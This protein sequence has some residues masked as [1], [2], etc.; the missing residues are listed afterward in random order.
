M[1]DDQDNGKSWWAAFDKA[2]LALC[3]VVALLFA[4][5]FGEDLYRGAP[6]TLRHQIYL[7]I[8]LM[9]AVT[10]PFVSRI[11][12]TMS[13]QLQQVARNLY[14][15]LAIIL[16]IFVYGAYRDIWEPGIVASLESQNSALIAWLEAAETEKATLNEWLQQAQRER[17]D[18]RK[19]L[20]QP[21]PLQ[22]SPMMSFPLPAPPSAAQECVTLA[23]RLADLDPAWASEKAQIE[24]IRSTMTAL[25]CGCDAVKK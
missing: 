9:F 13:P 11:A 6:V 12:Q 4:L 5:P 2:V 20:K 21:S 23:Q 25:G 15:W 24:H 7:G 18:A 8:G 1:A 10:G 3:E 17:D 14:V 16:L 19:E 22:G